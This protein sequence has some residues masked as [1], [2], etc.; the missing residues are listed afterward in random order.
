MSH[1]GSL[2]VKTSTAAL[3]LALLPALLAAPARAQGT[4]VDDL[5]RDL[6]PR[7]GGATRG[8]RSV[9]P[10]PAAAEPRAAVASRAAAPR[11][12][13][14][15]N[16]T[17]TTAPVT[18]GQGAASMQI[19]F[20]SGSDR[21]T[22]S[23]MKEL[24]KLVAALSTPEFANDSF[25]IEGHTDTV[26]N[27]DV[28]LALSARRAQAVIDYVASHGRISSARLEPIG[29]GATDLAVPTGPN[30]PEQRNRRVRIVNLG[31]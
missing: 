23:A 6:R 2:V 28:N 31:G 1:T 16:A 8:I 14:V 22:P 10:A 12:A 18:D 7:A 4:S 19:E 17:A 3:A 11:P 20:A 24:D 27:P 21:L 30:V 9:G 29:L 13:R 25:R 15:A 26:G 5:I